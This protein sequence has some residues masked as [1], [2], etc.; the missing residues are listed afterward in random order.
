MNA[1]FEYFNAVYGT[2]WPVSCRV[3][4]MRFALTAKR[5]FGVKQTSAGII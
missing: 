1:N 5:K 2:R 3:C 4:V